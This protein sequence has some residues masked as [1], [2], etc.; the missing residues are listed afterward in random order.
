MLV[1][2]FTVLTLYYIH[3]RTIA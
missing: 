3:C 2:S 1:A